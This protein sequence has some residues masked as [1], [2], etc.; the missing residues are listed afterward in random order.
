M[1]IEECNP[2]R[3]ATKK[4]GEECRIQYRSDNPDRGAPVRIEECQS[5]QWGLMS[6]YPRGGTLKKEELTAE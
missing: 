3:G 4:G 1:G 5:R 6:A 2:S